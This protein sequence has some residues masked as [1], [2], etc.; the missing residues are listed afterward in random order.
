MVAEEAPLVA[1]GPP[2]R[3]EVLPAMVIVEEEGKKEEEADLEAKEEEEADML[4]KD[5]AEEKKAFSRRRLRA[6]SAMWHL[7]INSPICEKDKKC[8]ISR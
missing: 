2:T 7:Y 3:A 5:S 6:L 8:S 1:V 4:A